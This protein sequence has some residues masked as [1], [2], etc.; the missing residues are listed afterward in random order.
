MLAG[1]GCFSIPFDVA[2]YRL[3]GAVYGTLLNH[4]SALEALGEALNQ[5]PYGA[6]PKAP[7]LYIKPRNTLA[8][9]GSIV[10]IPAGIAELEVGACLGV[11]I[12]H[13]ACRVSEPHAL[14]YV[15]GYLILADVSIPHANYHRPS[16]RY[17]ARDGYCPLGPE[18][19]PRAA[20]A[21]PDALTIRS[22]CDGALVQ[23]AS[24]ADLIRPA[25]RLL[26]DVTEF[27]TLAPGDVLAL[28]AAWPSPRVRSG[29]T[30]RIEIDGVGSL[31]IPF[32]DAAA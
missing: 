18:V 19:T 20:V 8:A 21:N 22:Y 3:S 29:Q 24:T 5:P 28:G 30:L 15:A 14:D 12:G 23:T 26:A 9:S 13:T 17:K 16:I 1:A 32:M 27:M 4:R 7:V 2:P 10:R 6:A 31:S 11:V 25:A